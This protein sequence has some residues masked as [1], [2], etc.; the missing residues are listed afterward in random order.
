MQ[1][2]K[3]NKLLSRY[4]ILYFLVTKF[5][6][7]EL[8]FPL[9]K[10]LYFCCGSVAKSCATLCNPMDCITSDLLVPHHLLELAQ[11]HVHC[12]GYVIQASHPLTSSSPSAFSL[13]QHQGLP[14]S[15]LFTS[16]THWKSFIGA[17]ASALVLPVNIQG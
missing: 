7:L 14:M 11:A 12:I 16:V 15:H 8:I 3:K 9:E 1:V 13:S 10:I 2:S 6:S 17:S 4:M 5:L